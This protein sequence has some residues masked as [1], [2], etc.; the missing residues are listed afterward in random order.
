ML[1]LR[2]RLGLAFALF[3]VF[4][5]A[6]ASNGS[7]GGGGGGNTNPADLTGGA[8]QLD[9][10]SLSSLVGQLPA[11]A[12]VTIEFKEGHATGHSGCN[13][14]GGSYDAKDD[15]SI[16]FGQL[17]TTLMACEPPLDALEQAYVKALGKVDTFSVDGSLTLKG[18]GVS[19]T[20]TKEAPASPSPL[21]GTTWSLESIASTS[22]TS[23]VVAQG[24]VTLTLAP[25]GT[26][27]GFGG[28]NNYHGG[29]ET[30]GSSLRFKHIA[31][32]KMA[33]EQDLMTL[34][35]IFMTALGQTVAYSIEGSSLTLEDT[36]GAALLEFSAVQAG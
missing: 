14:Y 4:L 15:G 18:S 22:T 30:S 24:K 26:A 12:Q 17:R 21:V 2:V 1:P 8:W 3:P 36:S 34:E 23:S 31:S 6:C 29:Y 10:Q 5:A 32:T 33:C 35:Q 25:D 20:Y 19:L 7:G 16:S 28:C 9:A 11:N 27:S 13:Q